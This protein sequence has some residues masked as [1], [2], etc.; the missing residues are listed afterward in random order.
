MTVSTLLETIYHFLSSS[1]MYVRQRNTISETELV[2]ESI[3]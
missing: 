2:A 3:K 1:V